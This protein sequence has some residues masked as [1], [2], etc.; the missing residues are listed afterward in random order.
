[1]NINVKNISSAESL[2]EIEG[3]IGVEEE[4]QFGQ[5]E[6]DTRVSTY[7]R[8]RSIIENISTD[9]R[10]IRLNI[11]ST[12][13]SVQDALLIYSLLVDLSAT[14]EIETH[15]YGFSA[16]AATIIAQAATAGRRYVA[17]SALYMIHNAS[18]QFDGNAVDAESVAAML[19]KTDGQI[20]SIYAERSGRAKEHFADIMGR[21]NGRGEWLT[22]EE[23]VEAGLADVIENFS[24]IRNF[25]GEVRN[26]FT[27]LLG[28]NLPKDADE[29]LQAPENQMILDAVPT[30]TIPKDDP[31]IEHF[32]VNL[33]AN[34]SSYNRDIE[35]FKV[36]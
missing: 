23:A 35:L 7:D 26:F 25:V 36:R 10:K 18:T 16:S 3:V 4:Y 20:A 5:D 11:R 24:T 34:Q 6:A 21:D 28:L 8:F 1:M 31:Q 30:K 14:V 19:A 15:C 32:S 9:V 29:V 27:S 13:G 2:I 22:P 33:S 12:G 17:S